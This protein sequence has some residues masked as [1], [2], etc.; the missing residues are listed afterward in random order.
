MAKNR[1]SRYMNG[2]DLWDQCRQINHTWNILDILGCP[3]SVVGSG[4]F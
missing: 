4:F 3:G 2:L 1:G